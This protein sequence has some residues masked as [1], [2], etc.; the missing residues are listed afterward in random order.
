MKLPAKLSTLRKPLL[1][2]AIGCAMSIPALAQE[3]KLGMSSPPTS[4]DPHFYNLVPNLNVSD[5]IFETLVTF[6]PDM[7]VVPALAESWKLVNDTTWEFKLRKGVKFHDGSEFTADDVA[8][9]IDRPA[10][11]VNSPGKFDTYTKAI[12]TKTIVDPHT[13]RFTTK[14][15][16]PLM[17]QDLA[18]VYMVSK[19]ATQ[20]VASDEFASGKG[21]VGTGPYKFVKFQRDDR[22]ELA[23]NDDYWGK[24][25]AWSKVTL[26]FIPNDATRT[27]ALLAGDVQA[28][29]NVPTPDLTRIRGDAKLSMF[30]KVSNRL[31]YLYADTARSKSPLVT[32]KE[33]K[34][35]DKNPLQDIRVR[36]ALSMAINREAIKERVM[37]GLSV[38]AANL[39]PINLFGFN[40]QLHDK[41]DAEGAKK[42]LAE[43][44]YPNGFGLTIDTPN[45]RYINDER[46][47][48][49]VAQMWS[50]IG[51]NTKVEGMPMAVY[52]SRGAK[53]EYSMGLLGWA[54]Q[55]GEA[56]SP[57][58]AL[59]A[60]QDPSKG[61]GGFNWLKYCN[62]KLDQALVKALGSINDADRLKSLQEAAAIG[63][64]DYAL[65][66][67]HH[68][69]T[70]WAAK[71]GVSFV[72][73]TDE[74]THAFAFSQ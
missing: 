33:G 32:D 71:K 45:N 30:S 29:E 48:Q 6:D 59:M 43:A 21:M 61:F 68:Q 5:H 51:V 66:P 19:K 39:V 44:G 60:C 7:K 50:R 47:V 11:I 18:L 42:L 8:W 40:P 9:S 64:G 27:A 63:L 1:A 17:L 73:R 12:I 62:P 20:G 37:E 46:I 24:K 54:A 22:V 10:T 16:Y 13:I 58:R 25:P 74:R 3:F 67:I 26:R 72:P 4:M 69:V 57:L 35:L 55:T 52:A 34:P 28:I 31:I 41:Y 70:T 15:A 53:G 23:R 65:I 36:K 56:S 38:P 2:L 14:E 49:T